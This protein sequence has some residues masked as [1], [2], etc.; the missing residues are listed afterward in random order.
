MEI[1]AI[2]CG[3]V[4][5]LCLLIGSI[6]LFVSKKINKKYT[7]VTT[8]TIV[9]FTWNASAFNVE[10]AGD[11]TVVKEGE[12]F[13]VH[14]YV[15]GRSS[16]ALQRPYTKMLH[17]VFTYAVNGTEYIRADAVR[18]S[19]DLLKKW[20]GKTVPVYYDETNPAKAG[21]SSGKGYKLVARI[22]LPIGALFQTVVIVMLML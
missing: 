17:K 3:C 12:H 19:M 1:A 18:Y 6:F 8:G 5:G 14:A 11:K 21:L 22:L 4:G 7:G 15:G 9:D 20:K 16:L 13:A 2:I 10:H